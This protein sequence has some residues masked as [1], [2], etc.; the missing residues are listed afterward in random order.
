MPG[1]TR[2]SSMVQVKVGRLTRAGLTMERV[3]Q[4]KEV[5]LVNS[6]PK[7]RDLDKVLTLPGLSHGQKA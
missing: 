7:L 5:H 2:E 1:G 3:R 4:G 6:E